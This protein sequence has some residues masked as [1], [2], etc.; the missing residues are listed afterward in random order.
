MSGP[1]GGFNAS[2]L[3][4][5]VQFVIR[6]MLVSLKESLGAEVSLSLLNKSS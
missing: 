4:R 1:T 5:A 6:T 2:S 3:A